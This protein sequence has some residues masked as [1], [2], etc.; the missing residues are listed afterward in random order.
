MYAGGSYKCV[1]VIPH[2]NE[3]LLFKKMNVELVYV[4]IDN[5][6]SDSMVVISHERTRT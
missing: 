5:I 4:L 3:R 6:T 1:S 2:K